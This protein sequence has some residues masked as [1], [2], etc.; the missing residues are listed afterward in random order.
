MM[1]KRRLTGPLR[2]GRAVGEA[3][4]PTPA[5]AAVLRALGDFLNYT[6][7]ECWPSKATIA[8][9]AHVAESTA[10]RGMNQLDAL[11]VVHR[12][13]ARQRVA[14]GA[15][16]E[17]IIYR[18]D[19][20]RLEALRRDTPPDQCEGG[21]HSDGHG[22]PVRV[23]GGPGHTD[24]QTNQSESDHKNTPQELSREQTTPSQADRLAIREA[25]QGVGLKGAGL[26]R[27]CGL[28]LSL[29]VVR[30]EIGRLG[31]AGVKDPP[32]FLFMRL[33]DR[34]GIDHKSKTAEE[35]RYFGEEPMRRLQAARNRHWQSEDIEVE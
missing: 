1:A 26:D 33:H 23:T 21:A 22:S 10:S 27:C 30:D 35:R 34:A 29:A 19:I 14:A 32:A 9:H 12:P 2:Y 7:W 3:D 18:V 8:A 25:L 4:L 28:G 17:R 24:T 13:S 15:T 31:A 6:T 20:E 16:R 5:A 11:G